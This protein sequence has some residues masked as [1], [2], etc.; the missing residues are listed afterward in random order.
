MDI[1]YD[2]PGGKLAQT[3]TESE[4]AAESQSKDS[5]LAK[6]EEN[7][8]IIIHQV[9][10]AKTGQDPGDDWER[11][12]VEGLDGII[13]A[14]GLLFSL[15][16][17]AIIWITEQYYVYYARF[18]DYVKRDTIRLPEPIAYPQNNDYLVNFHGETKNH[19]PVKDTLLNVTF[20][21]VSK[22]QR[23]V[24]MLQYFKDPS[25]GK[26]KAMWKDSLMAATNLANF[27]NPNSLPFK[28]EDFLCDKV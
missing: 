27:E 12:D 11:Q 5:T 16:G 25:T 3:E 13:V 9:G 24:Q 7:T 21:D 20:Q 17:I 1:T 18:F 26:C 28:S 2:V 19:G 14:F 6:T 10:L 23:S 4:T 22:A 15:Y 8:H